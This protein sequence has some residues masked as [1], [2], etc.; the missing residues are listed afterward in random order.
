METIPQMRR[1]HK[2]ERTALIAN[3]VREA[4]SINGASLILGIDRGVIYRE[5]EQAGI[6]P[7]DLR[8]R[9]ART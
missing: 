7:S 8:N 4:G 1:R 6:A 5:L 9:E 2:Q 3:A